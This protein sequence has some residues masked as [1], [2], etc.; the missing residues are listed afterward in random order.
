MCTQGGQREQVTG[1][2]GI[3]VRAPQPL[4][5]TPPPPISRPG[6]AR[7]SKGKTTDSDSVN[8]G[9]N[10]R[11]ASNFHGAATP[12]SAT[13]SPS[14]PSRISD[15]GERPP[16]PCE[17]FGLRIIQRLLAGSLTSVWA[18][19]VSFSQMLRSSANHSVEVLLGNF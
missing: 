8:R 3:P 15:A 12:P 19:R 10:P 4:P 11:R 6:A 2:G 1:P 17:V 14:L 7:S 18:G 9:S 16:F 13:S 5:P